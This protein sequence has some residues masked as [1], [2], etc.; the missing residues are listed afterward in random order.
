MSEFVSKDEWKDAC[1]EIKAEVR[2]LSDRLYKDNGRLSIQTRIGRIEVNMR[3]L[4]YAIV[5]MLVTWAAE[6]VPA[7]VGLVKGL[8]G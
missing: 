6:N 5:I 2:G 7:L 1:E 4:F 3:Y 8:A